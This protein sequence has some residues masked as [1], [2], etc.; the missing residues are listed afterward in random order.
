VQQQAIDLLA[1]A[2]TRQ[3]FFEQVPQVIELIRDR[4]AELRSQQVDYRDLALTYR[5]T[6]DPQEYRHNTLNAVVARQLSQRGV[7]LHP[8][9]SIRYVITDAKARDSHARARP[10]D[11][12]DSSCGYDVEKYAE[13]LLR[14]MATI[15]QPAGLDQAQIKQ[16]LTQTQAQPLA[17]QIPLE[18]F[19]PID[20]RDFAGAG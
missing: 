3:E 1:V 18:W 4:L 11:L 16:R 14:A 15:L 2:R 12:M 6:R 19:I 8:G 5:L 7:S 20:R 13:L 17:W 10:V 9:E